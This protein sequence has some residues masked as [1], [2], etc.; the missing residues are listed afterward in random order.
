MPPKKCSAKVKVLDAPFPQPLLIPCGTVFNPSQ[1]LCPNRGNHLLTLKTGYCNNGWCEGTK[2][3]DWKG[4]PVPTCEFYLTCPCKCHADL[5]KM[6]QMTGNERRLMDKSAYVHED[7]GF[8]LP[9]LLD[10]SAD[11]S[12][13]TVPDVDTPTLVESAAPDTVPAIL[14]G[15]YGPTSS[16]RAARGELEMWVHEQCNI[17]VIE[18]SKWLCTPKYLAEQIADAQAIAPPS[19]GAI[20]AIFERW[21]KLDFAVIEKKPTRFIRYTEDG[22]KLGLHGIKARNKR[23]KQLA[24]AERHRGAGI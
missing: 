22:I 12:P 5:D 8:V 21:V 15:S 18:E 14:R 11:P 23:A 9:S 13:S 16:G 19:V 20:S 10:T 7:D 2:A 4:R 6:F 3:T 1:G 24:E 17:W